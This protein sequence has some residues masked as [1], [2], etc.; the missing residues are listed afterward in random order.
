MSTLD[1]LRNVRTGSFAKIFAASLLLACCSATHAAPAVRVGDIPE[2]SLGSDKEGSEIRLADL[3]GKVAVVS[4]WAS[5]CP[6]CRAELPILDNLQRRAGAERLRV[7]SINFKE[8]RRDYLKLHKELEKAGIALT[9]THDARGA[10]SK[11]FGVKVLP[12]LFVIDHAGKVAHV[13]VGYADSMLDGFI[14]E[15]NA[16]LAA[17]QAQSQSAESAGTGSGTGSE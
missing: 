9:M 14:D 17:Q 8:P 6:P 12:H 11:R 15:I 7:V 3:R 16:L 4:F 1:L 2:V 5:W 10:I 13:H